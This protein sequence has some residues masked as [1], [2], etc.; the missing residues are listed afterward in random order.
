MLLVSCSSHCVLSRVSGVVSY[1]CPHQLLV[2]WNLGL[3]GGHLRQE[4]REGFDE[5]KEADCVMAFS[6]L[7]MAQRDRS[8]YGHSWLLHKFK[9]PSFGNSEEEEPCRGGREGG[10]SGKPE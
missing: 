1:S 10:L 5:I 4:R 6:N 7:A 9:Q 2:E 8:T 3:G